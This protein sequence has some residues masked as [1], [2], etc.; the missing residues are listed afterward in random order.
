[1]DELTVADYSILH[2]IVNFSF[3]YTGACYLDLLLGLFFVSFFSN[4]EDLEDVSFAQDFDVEASA[5]SKLFFLI[6]V[7]N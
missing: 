2:V 3:V 6:H 1:M 5:A 7:V 4:V